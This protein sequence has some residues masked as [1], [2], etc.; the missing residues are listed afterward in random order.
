MEVNVVWRHIT[1]TGR[2]PPRQPGSRSR[3][4]DVAKRLVK[5]DDGGVEGKQSESELYKKIIR[6]AKGVRERA[7]ES[8]RS[9]RAARKRRGNSGQGD[10]AGNKRRGFRRQD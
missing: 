7:A 3:R 6:R 2:P 1:S 10:D 8:L 5:R 4:D 9:S